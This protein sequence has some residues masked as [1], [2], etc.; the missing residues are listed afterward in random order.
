MNQGAIANHA[1]RAAEATVEAIFSQYGYSKLTEEER[2]KAVLLI[3]EG[4]D[5][6]KALIE[7]KKGP[8]FTCQ[9]KAHSNIYLAVQKADIFAVHPDK[10]P[11]GIIV[12]VKWQT[13]GGSVDEK[14]PFVVH[15]LK[16]A[17]VDL[18]LLVIDGGGARSAS[19]DWAMRQN[20]DKVITFDGIGSFSRWARKNLISKDKS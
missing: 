9:L 14:F 16:K 8:A 10:Y 2:V 12:E 20:T 3:R 11:M 18:G 4:K 7:I 17:P 1:G 6:A 13:V 5:P 19:I 15:S